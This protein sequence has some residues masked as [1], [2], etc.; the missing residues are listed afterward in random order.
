MHK[1]RWYNDAQAA[2]VLMIDDLGYGYLDIDGIGL[3]P[4]NDWGYGCRTEKGIFNYFE[5]EFLAAY[6]EAKYTV[7]VPFGGHVTGMRPGETQYE[8]HTGNI[9]SSQKFIDLM[10]YV[11]E[12]GNEI[13]YHG[14]DHGIINPSLAKPIHLEYEELGPEKYKALIAN[15]LQQIKTELGIEVI[16]GKFPCYAYNAAAVSV[17]SELSFKWWVFDYVPL[18]SVF[19]YRG[20]LL[21]FP[22]N[23]SGSLFRGNKKWLS[24]LVRT[25]RGERVVERIIRESGVMAIQEH[26]LSSRPDGKRQTPN[27]YDDINSL[28]TLFGMLK[29]VD[30][31]Y[32][33]CSDIAHY[34][35]CYELATVIQQDDGAWRV[36]YK[37]H[38]DGLF[39]S[40]SSPSRTLIN[41]ESNIE[42]Q[43]V[44]KNC[45]W[46]F[47]RITVGK[48]REI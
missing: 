21:S 41:V 18:Q 14:H 34:Q 35:D 23:L 2:T 46:V 1:C 32:A 11:V 6:P 22:A 42:L 10:A 13:S 40:V 44:R 30:V 43:G 27:I 7:F 29:G 37:G 31:W 28:V 17:I 26:F 45:E 33:T 8:R 3:N 20:D 48:Y 16:G 24:R 25:W 47:D 36:C 38:W 9:F 4:S 5:Q 12:T 39:L 15:D 19:T